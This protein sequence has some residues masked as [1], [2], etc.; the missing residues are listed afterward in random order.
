MDSDIH[1]AAAQDCM[2]TS[3][4]ILATM[5]GPVWP[6]N[7]RDPKQDSAASNSNSCI[8]TRDMH[9]CGST[10]NYFLDA[11][12]PVLK[13]KMEGLTVAGYWM[14]LLFYWFNTIAEFKSLK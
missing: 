14:A 5:S 13:S 11:V 8:D 10:V 12:V 2:G 9:G 6:P 1:K 4:C 7:A 3:G